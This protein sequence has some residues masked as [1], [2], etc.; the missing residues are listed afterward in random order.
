MKL[1]A[2]TPP[3][4]AAAISLLLSRFPSDAPRV[5]RGIDLIL[6]L[7]YE[8]VADRNAYWLEQGLAIRA[9][10][11]DPGFFIPASPDERRNADDMAATPRVYHCGGEHCPCWDHSLTGKPCRHLYAAVAYRAI[12][13]AKLDSMA[14]Q[15]AV[16]LRPAPRLENVFDLV[17]C[18][19]RTIC[20]VIYS[21]RQDRFRCEAD[22]D[23]AR[24]AAWLT[25]EDVYAT[26]SI[27]RRYNDV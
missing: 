26:V 2:P 24:F 3:E 6:R 15:G 12:I 8:T 16:D 9:D 21:P 10:N 20:A 17:S 11:T 5:G 7:D 27:E 14:Q 19:G 4:M 23:V 25:T 22:H 18:W 13:N 1:Y